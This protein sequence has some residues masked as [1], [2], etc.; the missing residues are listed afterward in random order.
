MLDSF[1]SHC[2]K[3]EN[4]NIQFKKTEEIKILRFDEYWKDINSIIDYVKIDVE[5]HELEVLKGINLDQYKFKY[6]LIEV[7]N[8]YRISRFLNIH[9]YYLEKK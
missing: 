6:I 9:E 3:L 5:G 1:L 2:E 8:L 7:M 4:I